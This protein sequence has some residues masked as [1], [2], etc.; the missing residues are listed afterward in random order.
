[1]E[2]TIAF[3]SSMSITSKFLVL[4]TYY[5]LLKSK[6]ILTE[7]H[8]FEPKNCEFNDKSKFAASNPVKVIAILLSINKKIIYSVIRARQMEFT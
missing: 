8:T 2:L 6:E 3:F 1:M 5:L 4:T 7:H